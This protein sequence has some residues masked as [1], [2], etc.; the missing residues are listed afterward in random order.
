MSDDKTDR[1]RALLDAFSEVF[2]RE[3]GAPP[4]K[5]TLSDE[6]LKD[7]LGKAARIPRNP[8]ADYINP[9]RRGIDYKSVG[10]KVFLV[11]ELPTKCPVCAA[12]V[13]NLEEHAASMGDDQHVILGV[14]GS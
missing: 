5:S 14:H 3:S 9:L 4:V 10:R 13:V 6:T 2:N 1:S 12:E 11:E 7:L 8:L